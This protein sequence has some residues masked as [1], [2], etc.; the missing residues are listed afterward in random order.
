MPLEKR[1]FAPDGTLVWHWHNAEQAGTLINIVIL[2][3]LNENQF[4]DDSSGEMK[5]VPAK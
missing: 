5:A 2:D 1:E 4:L 3:D